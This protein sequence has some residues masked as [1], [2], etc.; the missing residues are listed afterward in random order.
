MNSVTVSWDEARQWREQMRSEGKS[1]VF[2]N[3][4]FDILHAGHVEL[5]ELARNFGD[6]LILGLNSDASVRRLK[7]E[8]RPVVPEADRARVMGALKAVDRV[9]LFEQD[10]PFELIET[11]RP[12]VL[13]KGGDWKPE[14]VVGKD[15]VEAH[16]GRVEIVPL[17]AGRSTT[18]VIAE[19]VKRYCQS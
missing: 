3:G 15:V 11:L 2:T 13:V 9:T 19:V 6:A 18:N 17:V 16:G 10:T 8:N 4:C 14:D 1:V 7:G 5:L 12:D